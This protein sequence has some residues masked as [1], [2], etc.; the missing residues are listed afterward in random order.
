T[1]RDGKAIVLIPMSNFYKTARYLR[2]GIVHE[3]GHYLKDVVYDTKGIPTTMTK[4]HT[5]VIENDGI[6]GVYHAI[7]NSGKYHVSL[8][9]LLNSDYPL[10]PKAWHKY[11][12][13]KWLY[14]I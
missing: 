8:R 12:F 10:H 7:R 5:D 4:I 13:L 2:Y 6:S 3:W 1:V 9:E 14:L 11:G